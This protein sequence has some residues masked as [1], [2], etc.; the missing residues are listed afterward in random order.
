MAIEFHCSKCGKFLSTD[1][2]KAGRQAKCPGC[3]EL[4]TV[5]D[6]STAVADDEAPVAKPPRP[7]RPCPMCGADVPRGEKTCPACGEELSSAGAG[8]QPGGPVTIETGDVI[9]T[10]WEITKRN[11]GFLVALILV[12]GLLNILFSLPATVMNVMAEMQ[13]QQNGQDNVA[14]K[15]FAGLWQIPSN[16]FSIFLT[17]GQTMIMLKLARGEQ[18]ALGELFGGGRFFL[19][20]VLCSIIFGIAVVLGFVLC[21]VPGIIVAL[22][23]SP[24]AMVL[25]G[26]DLPGIESLS[27]AW[28][29]TKG[30]RVTLLVL[31][32]AGIGIAIL[33]LLACGV[34]LLVAIPLI[35]MMNAVAYLRMS[36]Q[37]T[38]VE[39]EAA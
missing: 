30:N 1:E 10:A 27:R 14:L 35:A 38:V 20:M 36:G 23:L 28:E 16:L 31:G 34:G 33:G 24:F 6:A 21:I 13:K 39:V 18:A 15:L 8:P 7:S 25:I 17:C 29:L 5:P 37:P 32:F 3:G 12:A 22:A 19:R 9:S 4:V 2:S 26:E 11:L